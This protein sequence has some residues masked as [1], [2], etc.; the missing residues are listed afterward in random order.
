[1]QK[2][3]SETTTL[4]PATVENNIL[5]GKPTSQF[6]VYEDGIR[7]D[8][9]TYGELDLPAFIDIA[10]NLPSFNRKRSELQ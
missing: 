10:M 5:L 6:V 9:S 4:T 2:H 7:I 1:M 3:E 8:V